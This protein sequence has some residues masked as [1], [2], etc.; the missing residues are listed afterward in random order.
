[1]IQKSKPVNDLIDKEYMY[2]IYDRAKIDHLLAYLR[3]GIWR[4][5]YRKQMLIDNNIHFYIDLA[6]FDNLPFKVETIA[7]A[8]SV[9]QL[10]STYII[11]V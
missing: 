9:H 5:I 8:K 1:M 11:I 2:G 7:I 10:M 3:I 6:R 4:G